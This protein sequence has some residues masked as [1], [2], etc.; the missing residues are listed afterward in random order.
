MKC[1][2][3]AKCRKASATY[4][5][6]W[7]LAFAMS[8]LALSPIASQTYATV[9]SWAACVRLRSASAVKFPFMIDETPRTSRPY[10]P[11]RSR[12]CAKLG[13][14]ISSISDKEP[15]KADSGFSECLSISRHGQKQ[16]KLMAA[17]LEWG[18]ARLAQCVGAANLKGNASLDLSHE[19]NNANPIP[20][21]VPCFVGR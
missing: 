19:Q 14:G 17:S 1:G 9:Y 11:T 6:R 7:S 3:V 8:P 16:I 4:V 18:K 10:L 5:L 20:R 21:R 12:S 2:L 13:A 15:S